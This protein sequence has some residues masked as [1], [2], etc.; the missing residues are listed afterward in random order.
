MLRIA[1]EYDVDMSLLDDLIVVRRELEREMARAAARRLTEAE[2]AELAENLEQME[3]SYDDYERFRDLDNA[4]HAIVM[5]ASGNE[6]GLTIVRVIH[7]HGGVMP[8]LASG[9]E[10]DSAEAH[11]AGIIEEFS[12]RLLPVTASLPASGSPRTSTRRG[13]NGGIEAVQT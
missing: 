2:L 1:L 8:P 12:R 10:P 13:Q 4:F 3:S 6:V 7:R 5:R 9:G 11:G